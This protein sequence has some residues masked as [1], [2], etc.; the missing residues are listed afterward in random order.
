MS[1]SIADIEPRAARINMD[2]TVLVPKTITQEKT[3]RTAAQNGERFGV[4]RE[5]SDVRMCSLIAHLRKSAAVAVGK[6]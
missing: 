6:K 1:I 4:L 5:Q 3:L 2:N